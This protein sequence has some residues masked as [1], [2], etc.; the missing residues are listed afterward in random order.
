MMDAVM[1]MT[2]LPRNCIFGVPWH[3]ICS[4]RG[5]DLS[6]SF[7]KPRDFAGGDMPCMDCPCLAMGAASI[8]MMEARLIV[9]AC[10]QNLCYWLVLLVPVSDAVFFCLGLNSE[11]YAETTSNTYHS[12]KLNS[13]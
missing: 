13:Y 4:P 9:I 3:G 12:V 2:A 10:S 8:E 5:T 7:S 6:T 1:D 11:D